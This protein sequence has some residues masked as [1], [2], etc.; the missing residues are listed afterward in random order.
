MRKARNLLPLACCSLFAL[1]M[2]LNRSRSLY[3]DPLTAYGVS[4]Y[5]EYVMG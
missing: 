2:F 5:Y 4:T 3:F 1:I